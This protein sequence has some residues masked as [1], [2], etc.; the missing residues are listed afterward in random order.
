MIPRL[1]NLNDSD[2]L[3]FRALSAFLV[4]RLDQR[5]TVEWAL[6]LTPGDRVKR[7]ALLDLIDGAHGNR[8]VEPWQTAW[9]LIE[10]S[11]KG[12]PIT[13]DTTSHVYNVA[14]RISAGDRSGAL[15]ADITEIVSP[16]L[17]VQPFSEGDLLNRKLPKHPRSIDQLFSARL[18]SGQVIDPQAIHIDQVD[19]IAFLAE[20]ANRLN[21]AVAAA[22]DLARRIGWDGERRIWQIGQLNRVY[23]VPESARNAG[24]H[25][26]DEFHRGIAP[27]VKLLHFVVS[28]LVGLDIGIAVTF[29]HQW[30]V[31]Q[32]PIH[33]RLWSAAS[34]DRRIVPADEVGAV[35]LAVDDRLFWNQNV[36]P[37]VTELRATRFGELRSTDQM[38]ILARLRKQP[39][40]DHWPRGIVPDRVK[41]ARIYW[42]ARELRRIEIGGS[43]LPGPTR[44]WL[45]E[46]L[47]RFPELVAMSRIDDGFMGTQ[48]AQFVQP[49]SDERYDLMT[50]KE[51]L[52]ALES[53][54]SSPRIGWDDDPAQRASHWIIQQGNPQK[55]IADLEETPHPSAFPQVW[56]RLGWSYSPTPDQDAEGRQR[57]L[58]AETASVLSLIAKLTEPTIRQAIDGLSNWLSVWQKHAVLLPQGLTVW[59]TLWPIAVEATNERAPVEEQ[60]DLQTVAPTANSNQKMDLDTLNTPAGKLVG[61]FIARCPPLKEPNQLFATNESLKTMRDTIIAAPGR[62]GLIVK[63]RFIEM[64]RYFLHADAVWTRHHLITPLISDDVEALALWR[65]IGRQIQFFDVLRFIGGP[66][67]ERAT[68]MRIDRETRRYLVFSLIVECL[69]A[70]REHR[71]PA[72][73]YARIQ[74][75]IR[76]LDDEVRAFGASA[77]QRFVRDLSAKTAGNESPPAC[78]ELFCSS[79]KPFLQG[80]WPQERSLSTPGISRALADLPVTAGDA[81]ADV[82][83]TIERFLVPFECWSM[84]DYG[85]YGDE[86]GEP[87]LANIDS[88]EKAE[89]FLRLLDRTIGYT[90]SSVIPIDL[91][92]ALGQVRRVAPVLIES[93]IFR[94]LATAA[95]RG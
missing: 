14:R 46:H 32:S 89:A 25:E 42:T 78:E 18:T 82:V 83:N 84:L 48:K 68:D 17:S 95:R 39:P 69:H 45:T 27:S 59:Y 11:W 65:A 67:T 64:V 23:Y 4:G 79:A 50:G 63:H 35:L 30:K 94:R 61:V 74:Q 36:N 33:M 91:G 66:M 81:F 52:D 56:D 47:A 86:D 85:L 73:S 40:R 21:A 72:V 2:R 34:R 53:S 51:R 88:E 44:K 19:H 70:L 12:Q 28:R 87:K 16:R 76:S 57:N 71:E 49:K 24:E 29:V 26:P 1:A 90:E 75:M 9:R 80:V 31:L 3:A 92:D 55:I 93:Q 37:E 10:E 7:D 6:R 38:A 22:I 8:I 13:E 54:L 43:T 5:A 77:I 62:A 58:S 20:L 41:T 60:F 15:A